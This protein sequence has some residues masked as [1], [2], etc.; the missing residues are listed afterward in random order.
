[1][2]ALARVRNK[3]SFYGEYHFFGLLEIVNHFNGKVVK[4]TDKLPQP[5]YPQFLKEIRAA[6]YKFADLTGSE[7]I[8]EEINKIVFF[9]NPKAPQKI[10]RPRGYRIQPTEFTRSVVIFENMEF[11]RKEQKLFW[12]VMSFPGAFTT[13]ETV[14]FIN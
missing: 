5:L 12:D 2:G 11:G 9:P 7:E 3:V 13:M 14:F 4:L 6:F 10:K 1:M 8:K